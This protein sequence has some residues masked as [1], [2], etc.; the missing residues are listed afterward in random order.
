MSGK[1]KNFPNSCNQARFFSLEKAFSTIENTE[2]EFSHLAEVNFE[3]IIIHENGRILDLDAGVTKITGYS[4]A[5][6]MG[7]SSLEL[8]TQTSQKIF[9]NHVLCGCGKACEVDVVKKDGS[10]VTVEMQGKI[11][12]FQ[13]QKIRLVAV[14]DITRRKQVEE[15]LRRRETF[16]RKQSQILVQLAKSKTLQQGNLLAAIR[17]IT[18]AA[19]P[20]MEVKR[21]SVWLYNSDRSKIECV[22]LYDTTTQRHSSGL[23]LSQ[24]NFPAYFQA[25]ETERSIAAHNAFDD[26]RTKE[27]SEFYLQVHGIASMLVAPIWSGGRLLG[28]VC[29]EHIGSVRQWT[30]EEENF[31]ASIADFITLAVEATERCRAQEALRQSEAQ[32]RAI[33]ERSSVGIGLLDLKARIVDT[34]PVLCQMLGYTREQLRGQY[35]GDYILTPEGVS[36]LYQQLLA[37]IGD[38]LQIEKRF[39]RQDGRCVWT[40]LSVSLISDRHGQ[41]KYFLVTIED[42]TERKQTELQLCE[43]KEAAEAGSRAKSEF[44]A[45]MSHELR[46]PLNAIMGLSQLLQQEMVG[47]LNHKQKEYINCIYSSGEHLLALINDILDLS[48][49]ESGKEEL[50]LSELSVLEVCEHVMSTV[51]DRAREKGLQLVLTIDE[52]VDTCIADERRLKQ[53]LLN[54]LSNAIK[55]TTV[56]TVSLEVQKV[57]SGIAF[58]V[59]DTGIGIDPSQFQFLFQPF[60]QLDSRLSRQYEGTGLGLALTRK[61]ALLHGGDITVESA[62]GKGS[63]FTLWLPQPSHLQGTDFEVHK[64]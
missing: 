7:K 14:K 24:A 8:V 31:T 1:E 58:A 6:L 62:L 64:S 52:K 45:T 40:E 41:P 25:L 11:I 3:G 9:E 36:E 32:F 54:L 20:I 56:G 48:K 61:L 42:I 43:S 15:V 27:L 49:V 51:G 57:P 12:P 28:A 38:R 39:L 17:E 18:E 37:G 22:D 10:T 60:K 21:V 5:E 55:F 13:G 29:H 63:K 59:S 2:A 35:F 26:R 16:L 34:N 44:L 4:R 47:Y 50:L 46:T 30:L 33:F 53:M 23:A 19:A